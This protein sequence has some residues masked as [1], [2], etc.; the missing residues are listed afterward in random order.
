MSPRT[1]KENKR[2]RA[3]TRQRILEAG[4]KVYSL[5]GYHAA[6]ISLIAKEAGLSHGLVYHYFT[7]KEM[8]LIELV[9]IAFDVSI[10]STQRAAQTAGSAWDKIKA[11]VAMLYEYAIRGQSPHYFNLMVQARTLAVS[12]P[13][14]A[15]VLEKRADDYANIMLPLVRQGQ[16]E[17]TVTA[18][19]PLKLV[20]SFWALVQGLAITGLFSPRDSDF[21]SPDIMLNLL[22]N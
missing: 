7:S 4:L 16:R 9:N 13:R 18:G 10:E 6:T 17:G 19:D 11:V 12:I 1:N 3:E 22:K 20:S 5:R 8:I 15:K 14:L 2:I 21:T